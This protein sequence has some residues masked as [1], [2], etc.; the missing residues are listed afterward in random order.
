MP[1]ASVL[2]LMELKKRQLRDERIKKRCLRV[3]SDPVDMNETLFISYYRLNKAAFQM[4]LGE[5]APLL[6]KCSIPE[7]IQLASVLRFLAVGSY[8]G[9]IANDANLSMGRYTFCKILWKVMPLLEET[10]CSKWISIVLDHQEQSASKTH[11]YQKFGIPGVVGCVD[12]TLIRLTKPPSDHALYFSRKGHYSINAMMVC[13]YDLRILAV[14]AC[15]PGSCHDS[16]VWNMSDVKRYYLE[17]YDEGN[18]NFRILGD[19][20]YP[21]KPYLLT[22][23]KNP[24]YGTVQYTFNLKHAS[25]RNVVE[26][27]IGVLKSR[28]RCLQN[29]LPYNPSKVVTIINVCCALHNICKHFGITTAEA[30]I[31][32]VSDDDFEMEDDEYDNT[33]VNIRDRIAQSLNTNR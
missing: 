25:A 7:S 31:T 21:L 20:G 15:R 29:V 4:V 28:F 1:G 8:Q 22:P 14:D 16:F 18:H 32:S 3:L 23:Y 11:F 33:A 5:L 13:D 17:L 30:L 24:S 26:R 12:G 6:P 2:S 27:T 9:V 19:S 10:L